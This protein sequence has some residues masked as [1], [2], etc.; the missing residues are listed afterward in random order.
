LD[1]EIE[2]HILVRDKL[3][4]EEDWIRLEQAAELMGVPTDELEGMLEEHG[5][6][7]SA[8]YVALDQDW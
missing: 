6:C 4:G 8:D 5:E 3:T 1:V 2:M 7:E